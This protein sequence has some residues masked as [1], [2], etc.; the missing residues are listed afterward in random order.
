[1]NIPPW[2]QQLIDDGVVAASKVPRRADVDRDHLLQSGILVRETYQRH[3]RLRVSD[4]SALR[5]WVAQRFPARELPDDAGIRARN[6]ARSGQ[7]KAGQRTH[8]TQPVLLRFFAPDHDH[9]WVVQTRLQGMVGVLSSHMEC[10]PLPLDWHLIMVEN[11][12]SFVGLTYMPTQDAVV[13][14]YTSGQIADETLRCLAA[15]PAPRS[16]LH[17]GDID[18]SGIAIYRRIRSQLPHVRWYAPPDLDY[19]LAQHGNAGL[20]AKQRP[21]PARP[22]DADA[23]RSTIQLISMHNRDLEQEVI[24]SPPDPCGRG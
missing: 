22:D 20:I 1:M 12:E 7:S 14:V 5:A 18:W 10:I 19:L 15:L 4:V 24:P 21:E 16:A 23:L 6:I 3:N 17:F 2:V 11:W 8:T 13:V 9:P